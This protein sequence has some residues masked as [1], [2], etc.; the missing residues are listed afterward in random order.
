MCGAGVVVR[1]MLAVS[2]CGAAAASAGEFKVHIPNVADARAVHLAVAGAAGRLESDRCQ[3][4]LT[5]FRD[6][7]GRTL[8]ANLEASGQTPSGYL[9]RI[10][11][12]PGSHLAVCQSR[13]VYA[14]TSPGSH[15]VF[16]CLPQFRNHQWAAGADAEVVIIH[17]M[18]HS[19]GL[20]E[21]PPSTEEISHEVQRVC[22][23]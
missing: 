10:W 21:D 18:L 9:E 20:G 14:V 6:R 22:A 11:F 8:R 13:R 2:A 17:E 3:E 12:Y 1:V 19:L 23:P 15:V 4:V 7:A 5:R 16:V